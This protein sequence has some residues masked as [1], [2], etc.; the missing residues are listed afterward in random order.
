VLEDRSVPSAS[1]ATHFFV[2]DPAYT[3]AGIAFDVTVKAETATN[4]I[5]TGYT[6]TVLFALDTL[7]ADAVGLDDYTFKPSDHGVHVFHVTM[8]V[9]TAP[10]TQVI[11]VVDSTDPT[12][13]GSAA[14]TVNPAPVAT[15]LVVSMPNHVTPGIPA[16]VTVTAYDASGHR[17]PGYVGT[18]SFSSTDTAMTIANGDLPDDYTFQPSDQ[19]RHRFQVTFET[20]NTSPTLSVTDGELTG[21]ATPQVD[22]VA[23]ATHFGIVSFSKALAGFA[24]PVLVVALDANNQIVP[25]YA[26]T[27]HF[28]SSDTAAG[29]PA[30]YVFQASDHGAHVFAVTFNTSGRQTLTAT[31]AMTASIMG[32]IRVKVL[33]QFGFGG[34]WWG[35]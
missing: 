10:M 33:G 6:G 32:G 8:T 30:D 26:G 2:S 17:V 35:W 14:T 13:V 12:I 28:S 16:T 25:N 27:V 18:I 31:D 3:Q 21:S 19:G 29:L 22:A 20:P 7:D 23:V 1:P 4:R 24:T 9:P 34:W 15:Q 5:A 11:S